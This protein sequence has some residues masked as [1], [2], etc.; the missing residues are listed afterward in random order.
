MTKSEHIEILKENS[1]ALNE[2]LS[3]L[4]RSYGICKKYDDFTNL[5][6]EA[7]DAFEAL[8]SRF[9]RTA[10]LIFNKV[11][12]SLAYISEGENLSWLDV[13]ILME[14]YGVIES[15]ED[16]RIIKELRND[17]LHEYILSDITVLFIE[18]LNQCPA[19]IQFADNAIQESEKLQ[20]KLKQL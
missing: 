15:A 4:K 16:A 12:R 8:T 13:L 14:K 17:I 7:M 19:L 3:W 1:D 5:N 11:F 10:D 9:A 20:A 2:A 18:V 6:S